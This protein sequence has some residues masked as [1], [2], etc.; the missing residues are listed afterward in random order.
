MRNIAYKDNEEFVKIVRCPCGRNMFSI[1]YLRSPVKIKKLSTALLLFFFAA[2]SM[3]QTNLDSLW[4]VWNNEKQNDTNRLNAL[5]KIIWDGF[6]YTNTDSAHSLTKIEYAFAEKRGLKK[7]IG[8]A[9]NSEGVVYLIQGKYDNALANFNKAKTIYEELKDRERIATMLNNIGLVY[10]NKGELENAMDYYTQSLKIREEIGDKKGMG[11]SI[12]TI[13]YIQQ[14]QGDFGNA[15]K[16]Y[17]KS[18]KLKE[19]TGDKRGMA[20]TLNNLGLLYTEQ[21]ET[22]KALDYHKQSLKIKEELKDSYGIAVSLSN[23]AQI[24]LNR[25]HYNSAMDL[26]VR[27]LKIQEEIGDKESQGITLRQIGTIYREQRDFTGASDYFQRSLKLREEIGDQAGIAN[28]Q[29]NIAMNYLLQ[30]DYRKAVEY[31]NKALYNADFVGH[32]TEIRDA[33]YVLYRSY[34]KQKKFDDALKMYERYTHMKDSTENATVKKELAAQESKFKYEKD[35]IATSLEYKQQ[36]EMR[37]LEYNAQLERERNR[38]YFLYAG[39]VFLMAVGFL[40]F[41]SY[42]IKK[43]ANELL[44]AQKQEISRQ[45]EKLE[46]AN[47]EIS[48][49]KTDIE[50]KNKEIVDSI[51]YAKRLQLAILP[52]DEDFRKTLPDAFVFYRPKDIVSGDF[53]FL[54]QV[55]DRIFFAVADCTGHGVSGAF[56]SFVGHE[57]LDHAIND[58][59]LTDPGKILDSVRQQV[60]KTF[61]KNEKGEVK[62]GMDVSLGV[63]NTKSNTLHFSG[64][65][66]TLYLVTE[67]NT[68]TILEKAVL[69]NEKVALLEVK[70]DRQAVGAGQGKEKFTTV[71]VN[72]KKGDMIYFSSDGYSDQFGGP[73]GKKFKTAQFK[74]LL[75]ELHDK[76]VAEQ[77]ELLAKAHHNWKG[78]H[79]QMDDICVMGMRVC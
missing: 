3:A 59:Q 73:Q 22:D 28:A 25:K 6:L 66:H 68:K 45:N 8:K 37:E 40:S 18:L 54:D 57:A 75:L 14:S 15:L 17:L 48:K 51:N 9:I 53:Y 21:N 67:R 4:G 62:D 43:K 35:S 65:Y 12:H 64:A 26:C 11:T 77:N 29:N 7:Y 78:K 79:E 46:V 61:D 13:A 5:E 20:N 39:L 76:P 72:A 55:D 34:N 33:C 16:N 19:E 44:S 52:T 31:G 47:V 70:G 41:R 36:K 27:C 1:F 42:R 50:H 24:Y 10:N 74:K 38:R 69:K 63:L 30:E 60:E 23:M 58:L 71:K 32:A 49:Q 2:G 56:V